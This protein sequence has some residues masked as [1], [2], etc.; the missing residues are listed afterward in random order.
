MHAL[1]GD[2][3][4]AFRWGYANNIPLEVIEYGDPDGA[5]HDLKQYNEVCLRAEAYIGWGILDADAF[6]AVIDS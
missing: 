4:G 2:F 3:A 6:A 1:V 5:G